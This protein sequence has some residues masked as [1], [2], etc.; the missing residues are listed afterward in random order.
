[1]I[2]D[3]MAYVSHPGSTEDVKAYVELKHKYSLTEESVNRLMA[4]FLELVEWNVEGLTAEK[5]ARKL[6][7]FN[8]IKDLTTSLTFH[9][10]YYTHPN[11]AKLLDRVCK[12][13]EKCPN[14]TVVTSKQGRYSKRTTTGVFNFLSLTPN[15]DGVAVRRFYRQFL[16]P[17]ASRIE[18]RLQELYL[19]NMNRLS[20]EV[21]DIITKAHPGLTALE[22][23]VDGD[24]TQVDVF[25]EA[26]NRLCSL[27]FLKMHSPMLTDKHMPMLVKNSKQIQTLGLA[28][29]KITS[30]GFSEIGKLKSLETLNLG[31]LPLV[32]KR[33]FACLQHNTK[34]KF[35][36]LY[37]CFSRLQ[38]SAASSSLLKIIA[39]SAGAALES[40]IFDHCCVNLSESEVSLF[41]QFPR[42]RALGIHNGVEIRPQDQVIIRLAEALPQLQAL[43]LIR[44]HMC[45]AQVPHFAKFRGLRELY[46][47]GTSSCYAITD[48]IKELE[49]EKPML[50]VHN[51]TPIETHEK[52]DEIHG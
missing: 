43:S 37:A 25:T 20:V 42:L 49:T 28:E 29:A 19:K 9:P 52:D 41:S 3:F 24:N 34:L 36:G 32:H 11:S 6:A 7:L 40:L 23:Y 1:M 12:V 30:K 5:D 38:D 13:A 50:T 26:L 8:D 15:Y 47:G 18:F 10:Y 39:E 2:S 46:F 51:F 31:N 16:E 14:L 44:W 22:I 17:R 33:A 4:S 35:L 45:S 21:F 27:V 48:A